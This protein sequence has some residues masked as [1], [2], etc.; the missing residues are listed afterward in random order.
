MTES[1]FQRSAL[2]SGLIGQHDLAEA[3]SLLH[4][5][6]NGSDEGDGSG[7]VS[8]ERLASKLIELG[9][10]NSWQAARLREG[11][12]SFML[13]PYRIIGKIGEGTLGQVYQAEHS[14]MG[15]LV[16]LK[17]LPPKHSTP[18]VIASFT[19]VIRTH[20]QLD[21]AHLVR[22]YDAGHDRNAHF[23]VT[24]YVPGSD[25]RQLVRRRSPR[26]L[27]MQTAADIV[28]QAAEGLAYIH[29][30]GLV[31]R[32]LKPTNLLVTS[33]GHVKISDLGLAG[34]FDRSETAQASEGRVIGSPDY[35][36]PEQFTDPDHPQPASDIYALGCT[37]YYAVTGKV[38]FP[39][40]TPLEKAEAHRDRLPLHPKRL[41]PD[42]CDEYV[43][44]I[45]DMMA[46]DPRERVPS[47]EAVIERL[48]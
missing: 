5:D 7:A 12:T 18:A 37:L 11:R 41:N 1:L 10:L 14:V 22:A 32:D 31:H 33:E 40:G 8:D 17:V 30:R 16:A 23:L 38:P 45:A 34:C 25:L 36:A 48:R 20:G 29:K 35:L 4:E 21:H 47:A 19:E 28:C 2:A 15:R 24:E 27:D 26:R 43:E 42:L 9:R 46:K 44:I 3:I 13:G 39:G 6:G